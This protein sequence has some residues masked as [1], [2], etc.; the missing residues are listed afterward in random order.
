VVIFWAHFTLEN[1]ERLAKAL[2]QCGKLW[3]TKQQQ[4]DN[5]DD[6]ASPAT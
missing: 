3:C 5:E 4:D 6:Q 1:L 2:S